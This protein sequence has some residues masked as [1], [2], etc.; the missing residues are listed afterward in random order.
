MISLHSSSSHC[1]EH[2]TIC[3]P[4]QTWAAY[5][6]ISLFTFHSLIILALSVSPDVVEIAENYFYGIITAFVN[7]FICHFPGPF[8]LIRLYMDC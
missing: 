4:M 5:V 3:Y 2:C 1:L 7:Y 6:I 8:R